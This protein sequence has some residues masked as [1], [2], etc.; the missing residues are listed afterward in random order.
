M[1]RELRRLIFPAI[2]LAPGPNVE[3][4]ERSFGLAPDYAAPR[5]HSGSTPEH[6]ENS[7]SGVLS[8][9]TLQ[10]KHH[11]NAEAEERFMITFCLKRSL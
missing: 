3:S 7:A 8:I 9:S 5:S 11:R 4:I 1:H 2:F 10:K 6:E